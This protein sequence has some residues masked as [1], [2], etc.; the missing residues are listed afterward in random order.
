MPTKIKLAVD[1]YAINLILARNCTTLSKTASKMGVT[2]ATLYNA[3][4]KGEFTTELLGKLCKALNCDMEEV[5]LD[6]VN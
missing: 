2:A 6:G 5:I 4:N 3:Y 1:T